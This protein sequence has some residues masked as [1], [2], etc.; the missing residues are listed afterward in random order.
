MCV[1]VCGGGPYMVKI[2]W[3]EC[4]VLLFLLGVG[5]GWRGAVWWDEVFAAG[6]N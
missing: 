3:T 5:V 4:K 2:L 1:C 6:S